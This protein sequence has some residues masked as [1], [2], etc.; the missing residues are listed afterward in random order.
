MSGESK[1]I[2]IRGGDCG[3]A[4]R[5]ATRAATRGGT[6]AKRAALWERIRQDDGH[7]EPVSPSEVA[8]LAYELYEQRGRAGGRD[9]DDWLKAEAIVRKRRTA[10][11]RR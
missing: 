5:V 7:P 8:L 11:A 1:K 6:M 9:V 2:C 3:G 4:V 10:R